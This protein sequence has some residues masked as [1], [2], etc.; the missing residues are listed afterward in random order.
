MRAGG[1][2][3]F[4]LLFGFLLLLHLVFQGGLSQGPRREEGKIIP[5]LWHE[6]LCLFLDGKG[7]PTCVSFW[8]WHPTGS[9]ETSSR[10]W[11]LQYVNSESSFEVA[12]RKVNEGREWHSR[13]NKGRGTMT[14]TS[15]LQMIYHT[16]V[17]RG[18][19]DGSPGGL[20]GLRIQLHS[21]LRFITGTQSPISIRKKCTRPS[22]KETR[23]KRPRFLFPWGHTGH[24]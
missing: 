1:I 9:L 2:C 13:R 3:V 15:M 21:W 16:D 24:A 8:K 18:N 14:Q 6:I 4:K 17:C 20:T 7:V 10:W 19:K 5:L 23:N 11:K 22:P 12:I